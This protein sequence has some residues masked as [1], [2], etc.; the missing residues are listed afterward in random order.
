MKTVIYARVSTQEQVSGYSL[1]A[2]T[3]L[4]KKWASE[5]GHEVVEVFTD[6]FIRTFSY[7]HHLFG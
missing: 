5:Q 3:E 7:K 2:Q 1:D 6:Y 4:C